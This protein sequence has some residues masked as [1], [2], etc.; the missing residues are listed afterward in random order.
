M[1]RR[2]TAVDAAAAYTYDAAVGSIDRFPPWPELT[3]GERD[4]WRNEIA[5]IV[6]VVLASIGDAAAAAA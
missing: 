3:E 6:D 4:V 2:D 1:S 5:P